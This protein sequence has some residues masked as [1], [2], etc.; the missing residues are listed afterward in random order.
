VITR[1][2]HY[3]DIEVEDPRDQS[4]GVVKGHTLKM[5]MEFQD[6]NKEHTYV[7]N[8]GSDSPNNETV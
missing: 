4:R 1:V 6:L 8:L 7:V 3:G 5:Y 2:G